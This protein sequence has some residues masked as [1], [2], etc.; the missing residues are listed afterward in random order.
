MYRYNI[1]ILNRRNKKIDT[2]LP[3]KVEN[4]IPTFIDTILV[5]L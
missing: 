2:I 5:P 4:R 3:E 1:Y